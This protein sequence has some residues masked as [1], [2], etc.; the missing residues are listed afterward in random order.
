MPSTS[1][2]VSACQAL[3]WLGTRGAAHGV[4]YVQSATEDVAHIYPPAKGSKQ[5][6]AKEGDDKTPEGAR[7][8]NGRVL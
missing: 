6:P 5:G 8:H 1:L 3:A 7:N 4:G 2:G